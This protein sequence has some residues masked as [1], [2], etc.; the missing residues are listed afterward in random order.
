MPRPYLRGSGVRVSATRRA[1]PALFSRT[2]QD[3]KK[4]WKKTKRI[5][6]SMRKH[7]CHADSLLLKR[8]RRLLGTHQ[9]VNPSE[10]VFFGGCKSTEPPNRTQVRSCDKRW[11]V[12]SNPRSSCSLEAKTS[13][14]CGPQCLRRCSIAW[15][16]CGRRS[17]QRSSVNMALK[18]NPQ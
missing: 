2:Q 9:I 7:V 12:T 16:R 4:R 11:M 17:V 5:S 3:R 10:S 18:R 6:S 15:P 14:P 1:W 8:V 13:R